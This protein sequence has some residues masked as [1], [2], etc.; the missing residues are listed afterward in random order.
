VV[1]LRDLVEVALVADDH[2]LLGFGD[3]DRH[4]F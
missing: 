4:D 2:A 3:A 1:V